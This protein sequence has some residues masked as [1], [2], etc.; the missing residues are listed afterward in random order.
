MS[1]NP[2]TELNGQ[3]NAKRTSLLSL[4]TQRLKRSD[5]AQLLLLFFF[6]ITIS[7]ISAWPD[8]PQYANNSW[9]VLAQS[10]LALLIFCATL[11]GGLRTSASE[12]LVTLVTLCC[13]HLFTLPLDTATYAASFPE[14]NF[15]WAL[16]LPLIA[17]FSYFMLGNFI[18]SSLNRIGLNLLA[19]PCALA[20]PVVAV[21]ADIYLSRNLFNPFSSISHISIPY[22]VLNLVIIV[23]GLLFLLR[24]LRKQ[25]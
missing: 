6:V 14:V 24:A 25:L 15:I 19:L 3:S 13:F 5:M 2:D 21:F 11:F 8:N 16:C 4:I 17:L 7:V 9:A 1:L 23:I 18:A 12:K 20:L 10:K 22:I